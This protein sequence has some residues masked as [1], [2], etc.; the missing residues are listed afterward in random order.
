MYRQRFHCIGSLIRFI[1]S[2]HWLDSLIRFFDSAPSVAEAGGACGTSGSAPHAP[3]TLRTLR[4]RYAEAGVRYAYV[5]PATWRVLL[6]ATIRYAEGWR[7]LRT[8]RGRYARHLAPRPAPHRPA[9]PRPATFA[10][11]QQPHPRVLDALSHSQASCSPAS[12]RTCARPR[13][14]C[15]VPCTHTLL[16]LLILVC[17]LFK[18][19]MD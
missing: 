7:T 19:R 15:T 3:R 2:I 8:L 18:A 11:Q 17:S 16:S 1:D 13:C 12:R 10:P 14:P 5:T 9:P 6:T 4:V